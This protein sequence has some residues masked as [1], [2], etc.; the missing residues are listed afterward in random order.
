M[1]S[2]LSA[3]PYTS[4]HGAAWSCFTFV[5]SPNL[6]VGRD[7]IHVASLLFKTAR[8]D[9]LI[10][11]WS[12]STIPLLCGWYAV[13]LLLQKPQ[14][15]D[16]SW[17]SLDSNCLPWSVTMVSGTPYLHTQSRYNACATFSAVI[18][19]NGVTSIQLVHRSTIVD[20]YLYPSDETCNGP[21]RSI[22]LVVGRESSC[23]FDDGLESN[24]VVSYY[25]APLAENTCLCPLHNIFLHSRPHVTL[26]NKFGC[27]SCA[28][29][30]LVMHSSKNFLS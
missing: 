9:I 20:R 10:V 17:K 28:S 30:V 5:R 8:S 19:C 21:T 29:M 15:L 27:R 6:I 24:V 2:S 22:C 25:L 12:L 11:L 14:N 26:G 7:A 13:V 3:W 23:G 1:L 4:S 18:S 16:S